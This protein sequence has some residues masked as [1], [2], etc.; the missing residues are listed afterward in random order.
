[1]LVEAG[2]MLD[3]TLLL[4]AGQVQRT[5][6]ETVEEAPLLMDGWLWAPGQRAA[7]GALAHS[8]CHVFRIE[9]TAFMA[10]IDRCHTVARQIV[11]PM[12]IP[13]EE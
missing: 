4:A 8:V 3:C 12:R 9:R 7:A 2:A 5:D 1:M 6:V 10:L 13:I 11:D